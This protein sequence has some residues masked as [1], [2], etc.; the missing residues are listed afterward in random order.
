MKLD[1]GG[2]MQAENYN[3]LIINGNKNRLDFAVNRL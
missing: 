1:S 2:E 3:L